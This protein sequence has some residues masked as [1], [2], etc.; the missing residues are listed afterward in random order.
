LKAA[1][2][3]VV[4][5]TNTPEFGTPAFTKN[6]LYGATGSPWHPDFTPGGSSGGSAA[7]SSGCCVPLVTASDEGGSIRIPAK[8]V[9]ALGLNPSY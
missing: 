2:A 1:G 6:P 9:G 7:L 3:I 5:K 8:F 4:G